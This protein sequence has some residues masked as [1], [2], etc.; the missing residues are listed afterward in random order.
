M[1][2]V[3]VFAFLLIVPGLTAAD[4]TGPWNVLDKS[5]Q[6]GDVDQRRQSV[7]ALSTIGAGNAEAVRRLEDTLRHDK[8]PR[9]REQAALALGQ[10]K[11]ER[12]MP[13][14]RE[15]LHDSDEVAFA[16]AKALTDMGD[17]SGQEMLVDV[18]AGERKDAAGIMTNARRTAEQK[19]KHPGGLVLMGMADAAGTIMPP[20]GMG[21]VAA[22]DAAALRGK[23]A[24]GRVAAAAYV[25]KE[26]GPYAV[27]LLE[28]A[29]SDDNHLV[30]V[31]AAKG[32]G[33][34]GNAASIPKLQP[35]LQDDHN[36]VRTMAAA[37]IIRLTA[38][39][40]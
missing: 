8:S 25:A 36:S 29:L 12:S 13:V 23:G 17:S 40:Q 14:L 20:A 24:P 38:S 2:R 4:P 10:M 28:W 26:P 16:A 7:V 27:T 19:L 21:L 5:L 9:V 34:R 31:E 37:A 15:A 35:L 33:E 39:V 6:S 1:T 18:L 11:S 22:E 32:L 3:P 30:R